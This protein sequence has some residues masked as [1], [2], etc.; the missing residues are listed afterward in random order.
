MM[1]VFDPLPDQWHSADQQL[2]FALTVPVEADLFYPQWRDLA[3]AHQ[4]GMTPPANVNDVRTMLAYYI[5]NAQ[6][7]SA[8]R[9]TVRHGQTVIGICGFNDIDRADSRVEIGY[10]I[11]PAYQQRGWGSALV[12]AMV[13][14]AWQ[15]LDLNRVGAGVLP[16]NTASLAVLRH[17]GFTTEG[18]LRQFTRIGDTVYDLV[19]CSKVRALDK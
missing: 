14:Q 19:M 11:L 17:N 1:D 9:Y 2:M 5:G 8:A 15:A 12:A 3:V 6:T 18:T 7:G 16:A 10:E 4:L 13:D